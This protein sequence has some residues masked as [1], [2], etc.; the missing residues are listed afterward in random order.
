MEVEADLAF[1]VGYPQN[2]VAAT[3]SLE[4]APSAALQALQSIRETRGPRE[5]FD[6]LRRVRDELQ[7]SRYLLLSTTNWRRST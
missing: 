4:D 3:A 6:A 5:S 1:A 7:S 2:P